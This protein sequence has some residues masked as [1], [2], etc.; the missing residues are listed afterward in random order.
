MVSSEE[1][2]WRSQANLLLGTSC[3]DLL[4]SRLGGAE[5]AEQE[6]EELAVPQEWLR[7]E[8][9]EVMIEGVIPVHAESLPGPKVCV[10]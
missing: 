3:L 5:G 4:L 2:P 10:V 9:A 1:L 8:A 6:G 7:F